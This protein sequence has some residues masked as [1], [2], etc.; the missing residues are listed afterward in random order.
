MLR[1]KSVWV[2]YKPKL[3]RWEVGVQWHGHPERFYQFHGLSHTSWEIA[4]E[5]ASEIRTEI[6]KHFRNEGVFDP[7]RHKK[8]GKRK[9]PYLFQEYVSL[10]LHTYNQAVST[11]DKNRHYV[12]DL[13]RY[14]RLYW[15]PFFGKLD[16]REI[17][18]PLISN[19][20]IE[21]REQG[22]SKKYDQNIM[23][24]LRKLI[25]DMCKKNRLEMPEFPDYR[26][27]KRHT[28]PKWLT[29]EEQDRVL[30]HIPAIHKPIVLCLFYHG[31][32]HQEGRELTWNH[33]HP[34]RGTITIETLKG[35]PDRELLLDKTVFEAIKQ[36]PRVLHHQYIFHY[37]GRPYKK[38]KLW[39]VI[40][41]AL[42][43]A[44]F[45]NV[46]P[47]QASRH[48]AATH[49]IQR[50]GSTRLAQHILGHA[51]IRTTERYTHVLVS[52]QERVRR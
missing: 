51:D 29:E 43:K 37:G 30:E 45:D 19:F 50:G 11:G 4:E 2:T 5:H 16:I 44:G 34:D 7:E 32:R 31:L 9:S 14:N 38:N 17:N 48:S 13:V 12:S 35:G 52:D 28:I 24:A 49:I 18:F 39:K 41:A 36:A 20:Y 8:R 27:K 6:R 23:D 46:V 25:K 42:D 22:H 26:E 10:W 21:L 40:R 47:Y 3:K 33:F 1:P 15:E